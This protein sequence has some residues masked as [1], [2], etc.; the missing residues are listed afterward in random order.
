M[1]KQLLKKLVLSIIFKLLH[2]REN[3]QPHGPLI[4]K[5]DQEPF[6]MENKEK[7]MLLLF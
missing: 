1:E 3:N 4:L 6:K 5:E 7:L 2:Q